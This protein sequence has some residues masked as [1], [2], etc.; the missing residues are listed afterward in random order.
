MS[1]IHESATRSL[2][3]DVRNPE[4]KGQL[5]HQIHEWVTSIEKLMNAVENSPLDAARKSEILVHMNVIR[6]ELEGGNWPPTGDS[7]SA[8]QLA[9]EVGE[10]EKIAENWQ[11]LSLR[12][13]S[14]VKAV[15]DSLGVR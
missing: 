12:I 6:E 5:D 1:G 2:D 10:L 9:K 15:S 13:A 4:E 3:A 14:W 7:A 8:I 11:V